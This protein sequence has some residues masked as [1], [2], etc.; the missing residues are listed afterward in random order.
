[1]KK[2][3][4]IECSNCINTSKNPSITINENGLCSVCENYRKNF[5]K[6]DLKK[7][8]AFLKTFIS[9]KKYDAMVGISGGKDSTATLYAV[10][11]LGFTP[12]AFTFKTGY[13]M[14]E[15]FKRAKSVADKL[16]V[17]Y[18]VIDIRESIGKNDK[19]SLEKM[20]DVYDEEESG[21]LKQKFKRLYEE[22]RKYYSVKYDKA[23]PFVRPCQI[24]RKLTIKSFY[25][26]AQKRGIQ[27]VI[28]GI[29][30]WAG[31]S[32][33]SYSA[34]RKLQPI[35]SKPPIFMVHMPFLLQRKLADT[36]KILKKIGW[37]KPAS[38]KYV[39]TGSGSCFLSLACEA[40]AFRML[41]FHLD[42]TRLSREVTVGFIDKKTAQKAIK[43]PRQM[44]KSVREVLQ[45]AKIIK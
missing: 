2:D 6:S 14:P 5:K 31:L 4:I 3:K 44:R 7:E 18:E 34:I 1:M 33:N 20:A 17:D 9:G 43:N 28:N 24:C 15:M 13:T 41:D 45:E 35:K 40:K 25:A 38:G 12:L 42:S 26:E 36:T 11:K 30:E 39:D 21:R 32:N 22:G 27:L 10:K 8:L 16:G 29:N 37:K 23:F 19:K